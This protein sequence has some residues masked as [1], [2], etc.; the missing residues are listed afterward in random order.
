MC[1][2]ADHSFCY[3]ISAM[4]PKEGRSIADGVTIVYQERG[5]DIPK[6]LYYFFEGKEWTKTL[7]FVR[8]DRN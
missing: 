1:S 8:M 3:L 2:G 4:R 5:K 6:V 7:S